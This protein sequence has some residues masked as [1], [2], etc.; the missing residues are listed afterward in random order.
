MLIPTLEV[1]VA[2][3]LMVRPVSVVVPK[4]VLEIVRAGSV[5]VL[6]VVGEDEPMYRKPPAFLKLQ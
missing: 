1:E 5:E 2:K 4:P 3:P 6:K